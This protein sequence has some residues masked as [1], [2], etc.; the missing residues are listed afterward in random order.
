MSLLKKINNYLR[1][2][3]W[4]RFLLTGA[5]LAVLFICVGGLLQDAVGGG[6]VAGL[7]IGLSAF[8]IYAVIL[9][10][11]DKIFKA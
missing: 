11:L 10:Y 7:V 1:K 8:T 3:G 6:D 5:V 2:N 9:Y 4:L